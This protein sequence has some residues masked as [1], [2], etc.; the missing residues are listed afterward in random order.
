MKIL[1]YDIYLSTYGSLSFFSS[2]D[3]LSFYF[4]AIAYFKCFDDYL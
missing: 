1:A 2:K 4:N 3:F